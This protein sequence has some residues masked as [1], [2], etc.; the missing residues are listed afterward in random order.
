MSIAR[1]IE[2]TL[3]GDT[4]HKQDILDGLQALGVVHLVQL[5]ETPPASGP[6]AAD[7]LREAIHYLSNAPVKRRRERPSEDRSLDEI[8]QE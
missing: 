6:D 8:V 3:V 7:D 2:L 1:Q 5:K 4:D